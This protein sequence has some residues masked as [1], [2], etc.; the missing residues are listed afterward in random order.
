MI[1]TWI[2]GLLIAGAY[3]AV[4]PVD[5]LVLEGDSITCQ[6]DSPPPCVWDCHR[7]GNR[8]CGPQK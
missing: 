1:K 2:A 8:I 6:E 3:V 4:P 7:D 5:P